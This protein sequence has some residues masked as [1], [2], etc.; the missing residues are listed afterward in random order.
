MFITKDSLAR[1]RISLQMFGDPLS[2]E[3][4]GKGL[5]VWVSDFAVLRQAMAP[6]DL[7]LLNLLPLPSDC[8]TNPRLQLW[9]PGEVLGYLISGR[10]IRSTPLNMPRVWPRCLHLK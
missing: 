10:S 2:Q 7:D 5:A 9:T 1:E 8:T 4:E 6:A 3:E